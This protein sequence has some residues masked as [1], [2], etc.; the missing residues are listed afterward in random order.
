[1]YVLPLFRLLA[2]LHLLL[3]QDAFTIRPYGI[4]TAVLACC[5]GHSPG[6]RS[7]SPMW[8]CILPCIRG[9]YPEKGEGKVAN[10]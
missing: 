5:Q 10:A 9:Q 6:Q 3:K 1:M 4:R 2:L 7:S 8:R